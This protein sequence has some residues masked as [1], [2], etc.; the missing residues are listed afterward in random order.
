[1]TH[2]PQILPDAPAY[3]LRLSGPFPLGQLDRLVAALSPLESFDQ[4]T[5]VTFD[6]SGL[7]Q[8]GAP[9]L[10]VFVSTV[11][12]AA[13]RGRLAAGSTLVPPKNFLVRRWLERMNVFQ[14]LLESA[15][16]EDFERRLERGFRPCQV[17]S[18]DEER[19]TTVLELVRALAEVCELDLI[20]TQ[21]IWFALNEI[22]TNVTQHAR[23]PSG[24]VGIAQA[25]TRRRQF[26]V[27]I[28][29]RGVG[30]RATLAQNP[31]Y[32]NVAGDLDALKVSLEAGTT[33]RSDDSRRGLGLFMT[34]EL[35]RANGGSL[36]LRSGTAQLEV[37]TGNDERLGLAD[38]RGTIV[39]LRFRMDRPVAIAPLLKALGINA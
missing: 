16:P 2:P 37:G 21:A 11:R 35:L 6:L 19:E 30:I 12:D 18:D 4:A 5:R 3:H 33:G 24:A 22:A 39:A 14:L 15:P 38:V 27:A 31:R 1:M 29:D 23:S 10:V 26:E 17:F 8:I 7:A 34:R 25:A 20:T 36:L 32:A 9:C 28:A 13:A